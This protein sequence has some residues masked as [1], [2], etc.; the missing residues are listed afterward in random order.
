MSGPPAAARKLDYI[1]H[2]WSM[3]G[4]FSGMVAWAALGYRGLKVGLLFTGLPGVVAFAATW[5]VEWALATAAENVMEA[6][7]GLIKTKGVPEIAE[8]S[9]DVFIN[10]LEAAR[11]GPKGDKLNCQSHGSVK[12]AQGSQWVYIND[13]PASRIDDRTECSGGAVLAINPGGPPVNTFFGGPPTDFDNTYSFHKLVK[14]LDIANKTRMAFKE[15]LEEGMKKAFQ[16]G[17]KELGK[18]GAD[19]IAD[20]LWKM[21]AEPKDFKTGDTK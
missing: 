14:Y 20:S 15:G 12:I 3:L 17:T 2:D 5:A 8:G 9:P 1:E 7:G 21:P 11:G 6:L 19:E 16:E 4:K 18:A 13:K 10:S